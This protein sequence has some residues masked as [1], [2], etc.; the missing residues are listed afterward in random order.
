MCDVSATYIHN[1]ADTYLHALQ[2]VRIDENQEAIAIIRM[3]IDDYN[4]KKAKTQAAVGDGPDGITDSPNLESQNPHQHWIFGSP[5]SGTR[6]NSRELERMCAP[7]NRD[8]VSFDE[9]LRSFITHT[10]PEEAP[11]YEDLIYVCSH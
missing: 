5:S 11:R 6:L 1:E 9:R 4:S 7:T 8:F 10:F 2:M 3:A